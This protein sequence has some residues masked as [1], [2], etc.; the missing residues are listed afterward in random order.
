M[1]CMHNGIRAQSQHR[2]AASVLGPVFVFYINDNWNTALSLVTWTK[3]FFLDAISISIV[4]RVRQSQSQVLL[5]KIYEIYGV[6]G[7]FGGLWVIWGSLGHL[8]SFGHL[9][10]LGHLFFLDNLGV[11]GGIWVIRVIWIASIGHFG[12]VFVDNKN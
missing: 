6:Y 3:M 2:T 9:G 1:V 5:S 10:S 8:G 4:G 11:F 7:I 12:L